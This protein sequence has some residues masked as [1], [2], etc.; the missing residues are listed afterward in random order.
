MS[1]EPTISYW[2]IPP[3]YSFVPKGNVYITSNCRKSTQAHHQKVYL[4]VS[5]KKTPIGIAVPEH[6]HEDVRAKEI[7]TRSQRAA[8]VDKRDAGI[9]SEFE[10]AVL[11][12]F[13]RIPEAALFQVLKTSLQKGKR[14]VGRTAQLNLEAKACLAV[15]AHI[16]H[17]HTPYE[18]LLRGEKMAKTEA[19]DAVK[20]AVRTT[21][22]SWGKAP[23]ALVKA[24]APKRKSKRI[25]ATKPSIRSAKK[26]AEAVKP[27]A[28]A[29]TQA[30]T[31]TD[32]LPLQAQLQSLITSFSSTKDHHPQETLEYPAGT[33]KQPTAEITPDVKVE[34]PAMGKR[35]PLETVG[36]SA[37]NTN[38][39]KAPGEQKVAENKSSRKALTK[40]QKR[41]RKRARR[42]Q[43][44]LETRIAAKK[45]KKAQKM[46]DAL[47]Q[48]A[49]AGKQP[50]PDIII[51]KAVVKPKPKPKL[52]S[53]RPQEPPKWEL[54]PSDAHRRVRVTTRSMKTIQKSM[55]ELTQDLPQNGKW[56]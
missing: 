9:K 6:I 10:K 2:D 26:R 35:K 40:R 29:P 37:F 22:R 1:P 5:S 19:R 21:A 27:P 50:T 31:S 12:E 54:E 51:T 56:S 47:E 20:D 17:C 14:K 34:V 38:R 41:A 46:K 8:A 43:R 52:K 53:H 55:R 13:P 3:L 7:E 30:S 15:R 42:R 44:E 4:V 48:K 39:N 18:D 33:T 28:K 16:R 49:E 45:Q 25:A 36:P 32:V 23:G 11:K 24:N